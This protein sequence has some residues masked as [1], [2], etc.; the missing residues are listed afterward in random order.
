MTD[1][2]K[3]EDEALEALFEAARAAPPVPPEGLMARVLED[4]AHLQPYRE[5]R[6][7]RGW[8]R[9]LGGAPGLGGLTAA[10]A[11]G[12]WL[13]VAS[14]LPVTDLEGALLGQPTSELWSLDGGSLTGFGWDTEEPL[15]G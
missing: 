8:I 4:A 7:W 1:K 10:A 9:L 15:D 12:V 3:I 14:P 2:S 6:G 11:V 5:P 13:G